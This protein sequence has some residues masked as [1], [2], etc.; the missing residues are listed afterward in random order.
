[1]QYFKKYLS[2]SN[3]G[4]I[5]H[6]NENKE[7]SVPFLYIKKWIKTD[8]GILFRLNNKVIQINF[9]DKSQI[10]IYGESNTIAYCGKNNVPSDRVFISMNNLH[11]IKNNHDFS[12][13]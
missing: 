10:M 8:Q 6:K 2:G 1:M 13:K 7:N 12:I 4:E 11:E 9:N 5:E 3:P